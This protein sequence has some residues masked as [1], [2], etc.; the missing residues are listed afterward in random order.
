MRLLDTKVRY[1]DN[2]SLGIS[3]LMSEW[4]SINKVLDDCLVNGSSTQNIIS[5]HTTVDDE[6]QGSYW[7]STVVLS[8]KHNF[9]KDVSVIEISGCLEQKYNTKHRV[10]SIEDDR[11]TIAF[12]KESCP[13]KPLDTLITEIATIKLASLGYK[14]AF[15]GVDKSVYKSDNSDNKGLFLRVD[16]SCPEGYDPTWAKFARV[17]MYNEMTHVDDYVIKEGKYKTPYYPEDPN[18]CEEPL[19]S[20]ESGIYGESKWY[21]STNN[22]GATQDSYG[23]TEPGPFEFKIIGDDKTFYFIV[24]LI[25]AGQYWQK[26]GYCFGEYESII[27]RPNN[28]NYILCCHE[29]NMPADSAWS[30]YATSGFREAHS[31]FAR[32]NNSSGKYIVDNSFQEFSHNKHVKVDF[33]SLLT[34]NA[35]SGT[36]TGISYNAYYS[37]LNFVEVYLKAFFTRAMRLQGKMRGYYFIANNIQ[38]NIYTLIRDKKVIKPKTSDL[39]FI[40]SDITYASSGNI[41][42]AFV[43]F[44]LNNWR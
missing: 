16:S 23:C 41:G 43:A 7:I 18:R 20:G 29:V 26:V 5:I 37:D 19:G 6:N 8:S 22:L 33:I 34:S 14:K 32:A 9:V 1:F 21:F 27:T 11:I 13:E 35:I 36:D 12:D 30:W 10:Q 2:T 40:V 25:G 3:P 42:T 4:G 39:R 28:D 15:V 17:S 38:E 44:Q 24:S 31:A